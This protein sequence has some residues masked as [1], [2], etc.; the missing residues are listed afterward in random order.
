MG[1]KKT[2]QD[3]FLEM[4]YTHTVG[5]ILLRPFISRPFSEMMGWILDSRLSTCIIPMYQKLL[6]ID[7]SDVAEQKYESFNEFFTRTLVEGA[8]EFCDE[9]E[10]LPSP[11][12]GWATVVPINEQSRL[13][14]KHTSYSVKDILHSKRLAK[15]YEGGIAIIVR[16]TVSDYHRYAYSV[17]G[18]KSINR[19]I[20]GLYHTVNPIANDYEPIYKTNTREY[21]KIMSP[22]YGDVLQMEVGA[23]CVGRIVNYVG[24]AEVKSGDE[25]GRFEFGGSTVVL[26]LE[27]DRVNVRED[28]ILASRQGEETKVRMGESLGTPIGVN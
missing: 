10:G 18:K 8:R 16:L 15:K 23:L 21:T 6:K 4:C 19:R 12:D 26:F 7:M 13:R 2:I 28:L 14:I 22:L 24:K 5:R 11:A 9:S 25:K 1:S 17:S 27:K 20:D 3:R